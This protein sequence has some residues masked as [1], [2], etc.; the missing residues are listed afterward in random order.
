VRANHETG[1]TAVKRSTMIVAVMLL[2]GVSLSAEI[3]AEK[4]AA[5]K[6]GD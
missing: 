6:K 3:Q 5:F 1:G 2:L 4:E